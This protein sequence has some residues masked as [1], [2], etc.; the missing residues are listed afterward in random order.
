MR[1]HQRQLL[2]I[3]IES[4]RKFNQEILATLTGNTLILE[5]PFIISDI[6][7]VRTHLIQRDIQDEL[8]RGTPGTG[9]SEI[10][11]KPG[12]H[13][14][15]ISCK[16]LDPSLLKVILRYWPLRKID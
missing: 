12:F 16:V 11:L 14:T 13:Y 7:P 10:R 1:N 15:L 3:I 9:A 8:E 2:I 4:H 6:R 5:A